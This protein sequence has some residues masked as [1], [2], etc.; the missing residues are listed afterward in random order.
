MDIVREGGISSQKATKHGVGVGHGRDTT[1][2]DRP[3]GGYPE[4]L[5][6]KGVSPVGDAGRA[7]I[8][9]VYR[10]FTCANSA[11]PR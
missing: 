11:A 8:P 2:R 4:V 5:L 1:I 9:G 3:D 10:V 7:A 6:R